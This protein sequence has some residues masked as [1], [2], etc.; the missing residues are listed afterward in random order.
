MGLDFD[1]KSCGIVVF[2]EEKGERL[3]L[4]LKY[5]GGHFDFVKG[6]VEEGEK[7]HETATRELLEETG[8]A[9][10][11]FIEGFREQI[12]YQ[13]KKKIS[14]LRR[15]PSNKQVIFFLGKT[16]LKDVRLSHEHL[17][18]FWL[19]FDAAYNKVTFDNAK[20]LLEK[21]ERKLR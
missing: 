18:Y 14:F 19:P 16:E 1:E 15:K 4:V 3:Y 8:I 11:T 17:E 7:E 9:D 2:R 12:S 6:H 20:E 13:Y 21:A 5:P 10:I